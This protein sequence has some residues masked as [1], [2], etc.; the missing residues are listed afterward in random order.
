MT[1]WTQTTPGR[2]TSGP[3]TIRV[4]GCGLFTVAKGDERGREFE[5]LREAKQYA[6]KEPPPPLPNPGEVWGVPDK[7]GG[8]A[9]VVETDSEWILS[10][11]FGAE[12]K[13]RPDFWQSWL[14]SSGAVRLDTMA[15]RLGE[16]VRLLRRITQG[17]EEA[18]DEA[19]LWLLA[20]PTL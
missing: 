6:A 3:W 1:T 13:A 2:W 16:A 4:L 9:K 15:A 8:W 11:V 5:T 10:E 20:S 17:D 12:E 7:P 14:A 18:V 19:G